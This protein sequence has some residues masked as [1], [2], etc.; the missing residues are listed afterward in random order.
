MHGNVGMAG[1][2]RD[3][4]LL[5]EQP[6]AADLRQGAIQHLVAAGA[7]RNQFDVQSRMKL[8]QTRRD[9]LALPKGKRALAR[10][11]TQPCNHRRRLSARE[12]AGAGQA[13]CGG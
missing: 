3:F 4:Q 5:Q 11:D 6:L 9:M 10:G 1:L 13:G 7:Q 2:H 8:S 12:R